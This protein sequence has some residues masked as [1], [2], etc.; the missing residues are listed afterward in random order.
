[1][2]TSLESEKSSVVH[3][4]DGKPSFVESIQNT[5]A[6]AKRIKFDMYAAHKCGIDAHPKLVAKSL[7][8]KVFEFEA[9]TMCD[10]VVMVVDRLPNPMPIFMEET[11]IHLN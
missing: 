7:G 5:P 1:M 4:K 2:S 9:D 11:T 6:D 8:L 10:F 3:Y